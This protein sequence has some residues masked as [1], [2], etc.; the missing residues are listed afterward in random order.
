MREYLA[1]DCRVILPEYPWWLAA[2]F[3]AVL[4]FYL[5]L[6]RLHQ[7]EKKFEPHL[8]LSDPIETIKPGDQ[9]RTER[10]ISLEVANDSVKNTTA[11]L[12]MVSFINRYG[13]QSNHLNARF[14]SSLDNP[15]DFKE[16]QY[17]QSVEIAGKDSE[18][19]DIASYDE[20]PD[21]PEDERRVVM[22]YATPTGT[23]Y[24][25]YIHRTAF[26]H[27][28][29]L[30]VIATDLAIPIEKLFRITVDESNMLRMEPI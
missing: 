21:L 11:E 9:G 12:K 2:G 6:R 7:L 27:D 20:S 30:K 3:A 22:W 1:R 4:V 29:K 18:L 13:K 17:R 26:P 16:G 15:Q 25:N 24:G 10:R 19:F 28:I 8:T 23:V 5:M 14:K